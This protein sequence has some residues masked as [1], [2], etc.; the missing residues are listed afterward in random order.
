MPAPFES[1]DAR[2]RL[3]DL[4]DKASGYAVLDLGGRRIGSVVGLTDDPESGERRLTIRGD[5]AFV[6]RRRRRLLA[7]EAIQIVDARRRL[8][9]VNDDRELEPAGEPADTSDST[10]GVDGEMSDREDGTHELLRRLDA[11]T[12]PP[13]R[14]MSA[15]RHLWF[16]S[17]PTGYR[18]E[19]RE[20]DP[21]PV[22]SRISEADL[23]ELLVVTKI[24]P[25]P[26]PNDSRA[27]AFL[28]RDN[29][30]HV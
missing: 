21:P 12:R 5:G 7:L 20:G 14:P 16:V 11:Y 25:S 19:D 23:P 1:D 8:T 9:V 4:L 3:L 6:W 24:G 28:E 18:L 27:C 22:G 30:A 10:F 29:L 15:G 2:A 13:E 17:T 26:L